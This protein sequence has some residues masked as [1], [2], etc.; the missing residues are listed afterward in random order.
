MLPRKLV[1]ESTLRQD[2][3]LLWL[4]PLV[5]QARVT[6]RHFSLAPADIGL[7]AVMRF[8]GRLCHRAAVWLCA[9]RNQSH[10]SHSRIGLCR[11][12]NKLLLGTY[13]LK[14]L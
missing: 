2:G 9:V 10:S 5:G 11:V 7:A 12:N 14:A 1:Y 3:S 6:A 4:L 8:L 13:D